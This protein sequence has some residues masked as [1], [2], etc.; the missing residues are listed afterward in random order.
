MKAVF[1]YLLITAVGLISSG[2]ESSSM[3]SLKVLEAVKADKREL[4]AKKTEWENVSGSEACLV[5]HF[6]NATVTT[7]FRQTDREN[8]FHKAIPLKQEFAYHPTGQVFTTTKYQSRLWEDG[9]SGYSFRYQD[10]L[11]NDSGTE[12]DSIF[13]TIND[14]FGGREFEARYTLYAKAD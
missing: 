2:C 7:H 10:I 1:C 5:S 12:F 3:K 8:F 13:V 9:V 6:E 11:L 4:Q 14:R